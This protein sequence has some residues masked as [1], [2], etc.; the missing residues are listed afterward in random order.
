M[1]PG[2]TSIGSGVVEESFRRS[3]ALC[4]EWDRPACQP[5]AMGILI[6]RRRCEFALLTLPRG[7]GAQRNGARNARGLGALAALVQRSLAGLR[8]KPP[9][10]RNARLPRLRH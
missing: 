1:P 6:A 7:S 9:A 8:A 5:G 2:F 3:S 4:S 10:A